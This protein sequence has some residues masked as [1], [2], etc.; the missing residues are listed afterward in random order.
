M[1]SFKRVAVVVLLLIA[2][3]SGYVFFGNSDLG[4]QFGEL[5]AGGT[6]ETGG[7]DGDVKVNIESGVV[8]ESNVRDLIYQNIAEY[9]NTHDR[10]PINQHPE[11]AEFAQKRAEAMASSSDSQQTIADEYKGD[12]QH[13]S[14]DEYALS[15]VNLKTYYQT[16]MSDGTYYG[17]ESEL[18]KGIV[19]R[20]AN[21]DG[22]RELLVENE[23]KYSA[24]GIEVTQED[25][26][27]VV[28]AV[29]MFC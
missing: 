2:I 19:E 5:S 6:G 11:L 25:G 13:S 28:Y 4:G 24:S 9:R 17:S 14:S 12:C 22:T 26:M 7:T 29:Q 16:Q 23:W 3:P 10:S 20:W 21:S 15:S 8:D 18:A 27:I 1:A